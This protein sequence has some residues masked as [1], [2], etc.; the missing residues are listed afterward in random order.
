MP[1]RRRLLKN[2]LTVRERASSQEI[3]TLKGIDFCGDTLFIYLR[4][5]TGF[6]KVNNRVL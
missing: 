4:S 3:R 5:K 2:F 6:L 1:L